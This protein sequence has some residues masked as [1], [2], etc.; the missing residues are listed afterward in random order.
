MFSKQ[1]F[2]GL[3][4]VFILSIIVFPVF[5]G[6]SQVHLAEGFES[7]TKPEG[8]TEEY[9]SGT[10]PW[11]FR[12]GGHSP[13]D[14]NWLVPAAQKDITRNPPASYEGTYNAIFFKQGD[15]NERT[16][17]VTP[18]LNLLGGADPELSF[19]L[20]QI[21]WTFEGS[22]GWDVLRVYYKVSETSP[23]IL[24]HEYIDPLYVWTQQTL[25][26]PDPSSTYYIGFE[27]HTRWGYGTCLDKIT[28][29]SK[30]LKPY[31]IRDIEFQQLFPK[32][33]PSGSANVPLM[34]IDF[35]LLGNSGNA[36]LESIRF[37]SLNTSDGDINPNGVRLYSTTSQKFSTGHP[38]GNASSFVSGIAEFSGLTY[39]LPPGQSYLWLTCDIN[40]NASYGNVLDVS[41]APGYILVNDTLYPSVE[42]SPEG[43]RTIHRTQYFQNFEAAHDWSL[44][45]EFEVSAPSGGGGSPGNPDPVSAFSGS[46]ILGTD[47]TGLGAHPYNYENDLG[48][49]ASYLATSPELNLLYYKNLNLFFQR[50][51]N[52]E[53][54]DNSSIQVSADNGA[55]W[56]TVWRNTSYINDFQW[57]E[58]QVPIPEDFW[59]SGGLR[60]RFKLGPTD[61]ENS[62]S[63]WNIDDIYLT[64]EFISKDVGVSE[65]ISP[66]SGPGHTSADQVTVRITN[67]GGADITDPFPVAYSFDG[68]L[69]WNSGNVDMNIPVGG[70]VQYT[71]LSTADLSSPGPR[72]AM[73]KTI[74]PGD[75]YTGNDVLSLPIY[76]VPTFK[77]PYS[78]NFES[79]DGFWRKGGNEI[80]EYGVPS[81]NIINSASSG[82][83]I[84]ATGLGNTYE[85]LITRKNKIIFE[86]DFESD[87]GWTYSGEF[88]RNIPD[89][90]YLP[91]FANSGYYCIGTDLS[92][93]GAT[94][95]KYERAIPPG[96][97]Y[98]ASSPAFDVRNYS[99]LTVSFNSWLTIQA[100]DSLKFEV[101]TD[102]GA[103]WHRIWR[104]EEGAILEDGYSYRE[105]I[106]PERF[107]TSPALRFRFSLFSAASAD[108]VNQGWSIDDFLLTGDLVNTQEALLISPYF[109]LTG[110]FNPV[111]EARLWYDTEI[112]ADGVTLQYTIDKG[113]TWNNITNASAFTPYWN[114]Y[115]GALVE[116]LG[117]AGWSGQSNGWKTVRH[118]LP[119]AVINHPAVQFRLNFRADMVNN[120]YDG[121]A[122]DDIRI[123]EAPSDLGVMD[124]LSPVTACELRSDQTF[125]LRFKNYGI[126]TLPKSEPVRVGYRINKSGHLQTA[127][128]T[129][130]LTQ[131]LPV[132]GTVDIQMLEKFD[133]SMAGLYQVDVFTIDTDPFF[134]QQVSN[135]TIRELIY[136]NKPIVELG[137]DISTTRPDQVILRAYSGVKG[138]T[139]RWQDGSV[140]SVYHVSTEGKYYVRV[141]NNIGCIA[142]DTI[143]IR[144]LV[145]DIGVS[146]VVSPLSSCTLGT[147]ETITIKITN[148]GTDTLEINDD[149]LITTRINSEY[150][151]DNHAL[152]QRLIP[153][154]TMVYQF[155]TPHNFSANGVYLIKF[156]TRLADDNNYAND[157]LNY[158]LNVYGRPA[159]DLGN[160]VALMSAEYTLT[161]PHGYSSY[162]WQ[163]GSTSESFVVD[164]PGKGL[165]HVTV[166][167]EHQCTN[168]DSVY[169][170]LN[171]TDLT[172]SRI[173][174]PATSCI[175]SDSILVSLRLKNTGNLTV[176]AGQSIRLSYLFEG[177]ASGDELLV[178]SDNL[179]PGDSTDFNFH[180]K[181]RVVRGTSY[182]FTASLDYGGDIRA[183]NNTITIPVGIFQSPVV[184]LGE[185]YKVVAAI[186]HTLDAGP[187]YSSYLWNDGSTGRTMTINTPGINKCSVL[188]KDINGCTA[189][190]E[191]S[192]MMAVP[193]IGITGILSPVTSCSSGA[194]DHVRIAIRNEGN[195]DIDASAGIFVTYSINGQP[196]VREKV[197][198]NSV[199]E[200]G[201]MINYTFTKDENFVAGQNVIV[202]AIEYESDL[203]A[204]NNTLTS[205]FIISASP[206][207]NLGPADTLMIN[208]PLTLSVPPGFSVYK[209]QDGSSGNTFDILNPG[210]S[211]YLVEVT[212]SNGCIS[213]DSLYVIY[214]SQD[215]GINR[216]IAPVTACIAGSATRTVY[217][218]VINNGFYRI[219][220]NSGIPI[221]YSINNGAPV[222]RT[223]FLT[224]PMEPSKTGILSF[225]SGYDFSE[226]GIY[227][228]TIN[229]E[230]PDKNISNNTISSTV[231]IWKKPFVEIGG[232]ADTLNVSLPIKLDAGAGYS[233]YIW[234]DNSRSSRHEAT[235]AGQYWVKVT[236]NNGCFASDSVF[237]VSDEMRNFPGKI[238]IYPNPVSE[239]LHL[240]IEMDVQLSLRLELFSFA[241]SLLYSEEFGDIQ[242]ADLEIN[243]RR[244]LPGLYFLRVTAGE[245][246]QVLKVIVNHP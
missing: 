117:S 133:F 25:S 81:G 160:D 42:K 187:G 220:A 2:S 89:Y 9:I 221:S 214:D 197:M 46:K 29:E 233:S 181:A 229:L 193:D 77:P 155:Q 182:N 75:Q 49:S 74:L 40:P 119:P 12:N 98:T 70:S 241:N 121:I 52:I 164:Q 228:L 37:K 86:D 102:N 224:S 113:V 236:D 159:I 99:N 88:E 245:S 36:I 206:S 44:T 196:S 56:N 134:Y 67:Y 191:I 212:G 168:T 105:F 132:G 5:P 203:Q 95:Y 1:F 194:P 55:S 180:Q 48:E 151:T 38:V 8:W 13:N 15:D 237:I 178:L 219:A 18:A 22:A 154:D 209:W 103:T 68:G 192:L 138:N 24:L 231:T 152:T 234:Q 183:S 137:P 76:I 244:Y 223:V 185:D 218:E 225:D 153:G 217:M 126:S 109:D 146:A 243:V 173:L 118:L 130:H 147:R 91:Y 34:R 240:K 176:T 184:N 104:N 43:F 54:W 50:H 28:I 97:A 31:W 108:P 165:Y 149:F 211:W 204:T 239:I 11:R 14:N 230:N 150:L 157:T 7:G 10:E 174:T 90:E 27:G 170:T 19:W 72:S 47:L 58:Q 208:E 41:V 71:F 53:V 122:V 140:D 202:T 73:A 116:A 84:W 66:L 69:S 93:K 32:S 215:I 186:S 64:G 6:I 156:Y 87:L 190:D 21:P 65:W 226:A 177:G 79:N 92:G 172:I 96:S 238:T 78:E 227:H 242:N 148:Y 158:N 4:R 120:Q 124:I 85:D 141:S 20:C 205:S 139:Y 129:I 175:S 45:G 114:W 144:Q 162:L 179:L 200:K 145:A 207:I 235:M 216:I 142:S 83:K 246:Q 188:V 59:R 94:P 35:T 101:S 135:D 61:V 23:W 189:F 39:S 232:G 171:V 213:K 115:T 63:G 107:N 128:E 222:T 161:A 127:E 26:L 106:L 111:F 195:W 199:F 17:L 60:M 51:H 166:K 143:R 3:R 100:G 163:N 110:I 210:S 33:V 82:T 198:L 167:D 30:G 125:T 123:I 62:Y 112:D 169:V 131:A 201:S 136:V 80:W 16:M 57:M